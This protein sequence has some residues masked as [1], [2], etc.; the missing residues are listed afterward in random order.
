MATPLQAISRLAPPST[1]ARIGELAAQVKRAPPPPPPLPPVR[2]ASPEKPPSPEDRHYQEIQK[3]SLSLPQP[4]DGMVRLYRQGSLPADLPK[5]TRDDIV[6]TP[7]GKMPRWVWEKEKD[8]VGNTQPF[9]ATGRWFTDDARQLDY[10]VRENP[11]EPTYYADVPAHAA[12]NSNVSNTP[13]KQNSRNPDRE[14]VLLDD[15]ILKGA[16][17]LLDG[18]NRK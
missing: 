17:K 1:A 8:A 15:A 7:L 6:N 13:F 3:R 12:R 11:H 9:A 16:T 2:A 4:D 14:F 18:L 5:M 10:Y